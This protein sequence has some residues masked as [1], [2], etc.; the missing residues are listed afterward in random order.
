MLLSKTSEYGVRAMLHLAGIGSEKYTAVRKISEELDISFHFLT[1]IFQQLTRSGLVES[2]RGPNGGI[3]LGDK[4]ENIT[5]RD[6]IVALEG[7]KMFTECVLGL[8]ECGEGQPCPLHHRWTGVREEVEK[9]LGSK[10]LEDIGEELRNGD[11]RLRA[12][13]IWGTIE[14]A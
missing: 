14:N 11:F 3:R 5:V 13:S 8:P 12:G 6:I 1:K 9:M 2:Y 10:T 4:E 7:D